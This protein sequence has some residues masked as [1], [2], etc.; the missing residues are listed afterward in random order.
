VTSIVV[1]GETTKEEILPKLAFLDNWESKPVKLPELSGFPTIDKTQIY[2]VHQ[3]DFKT[4]ASQIRIGYLAMPYDATGEFYKANVMNFSLGGAFNSRINMNLREDKGYTYGA[5]SSF[6]GTDYPGP[7]SAAATVKSKVTDSTII[8]FMK[9]IENFKANGI[10][11]EE[12]AFTKSNILQR[13]VLNYETLFQKANYLSNIVEHDLPYD[14]KAQQEA[15]VEGMTKADIDALAK[16]HLKPENMVILVVGNKY[17]IKDGLEALGYG[18][19][20]ELDKE[21]N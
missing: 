10:M 4:T 20:K 2:V 14:Y 16:K 1:V 18:K 19:V 8:E 15:L 11:E 13:D 17:L 3:S 6:R 5:R 9:E 12:L 21:G 7:F